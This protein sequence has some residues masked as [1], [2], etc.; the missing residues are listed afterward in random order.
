MGELVNKTGI[1]VIC[2]VCRGVGSSYDGRRDCG[3]CKGT[4]YM[5]MKGDTKYE[6]K[7]L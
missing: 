5:I 3:T 4:G 2:Q 7:S 6:K 1:R